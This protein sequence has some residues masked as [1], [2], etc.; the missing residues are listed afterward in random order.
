M[1]GIAIAAAAASL[2]A[3]AALVALG[4][5]TRR[6]MLRLDDDPPARLPRVTAVVPCRDEAGGV[7]ACVRSLLAQDLPGLRVVAVDDRSTDATG[8]IL[9]RVAREDARLEVIHVARLPAGWLGKNHACAAGARRAD[10]EWILFTD[11]DV[12]FEPDALRRA[13][14]VALGRGLGHVAVLP[15]FVA[16]GFAERAFVTAFAALLAPAVRI[17]ELPRAGTRAYFGVG[18]FNLVRRADY[19]AAGGHARIAMEVLDDVKLGLLLRRT[20][21]PQGVADSGGRVA[22][23]WQHGLLPSVLGLVKNAFAAAEYRLGAAAA[24]AATGALLGAVPIAVL[25][26]GP[27]AAA[28]ALAGAALAAAFAHHAAWARRLSRASGAEAI[29]APAC[30][31]LLGA[32]VLGSAAAARWR[33]AVVW[34]GTWYG[35]DEVR[36]GCLRAA[37]LPAEGAAGWPAARPAPRPAAAD[38]AA[39]ARVR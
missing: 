23:R 19:E 25:A 12:V 5:R 10:G 28:R 32:V 8:A 29:L 14:G 38:P 30:T 3:W 17:W 34:R 4:V 22:V 18:A 1:N 35:L 16:P 20:G 36:S 13:L 24:A 6:A 31:L 37:D 15:R 21:V 7:E 9:D 2:A 26:A 33:G 27:G 11:G 39:R